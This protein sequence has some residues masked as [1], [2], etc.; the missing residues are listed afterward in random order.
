MTRV[1][2]SAE[3]LA[4]T[5]EVIPLS[6]AASTMRALLFRKIGKRQTRIRWHKSGGL[7]REFASAEGVAGR[8]TGVP[9]EKDDPR[10]YSV[11]I[12]FLNHAS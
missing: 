10:V 1:S 6:R 9:I 3:G 4:G 11:A 12:R 8:F 2:T 5:P 7:K